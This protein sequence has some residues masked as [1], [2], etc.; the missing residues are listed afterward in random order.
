M[1]IMVGEILPLWVCLL[2]FPLDRL[3][4]LER[5]WQLTVGGWESSSNAQQAVILPSRG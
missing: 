5:L 4:L 2:C 1:A 3:L